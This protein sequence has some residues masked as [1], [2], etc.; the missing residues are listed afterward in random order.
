MSVSISHCK[1][2]AR[3]QPGWELGSVIPALGRKQEKNP[4][5]DDKKIE[6]KDIILELSKIEGKNKAECGSAVPNKGRHREEPV[7]GHGCAS[8]SEDLRA[9][10]EF[11]ALQ[12]HPPPARENHG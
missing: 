2:L 3:I 12:C 10:W 4:K 8:G 7:L 11:G 5:I 1:E 6:K 9:D